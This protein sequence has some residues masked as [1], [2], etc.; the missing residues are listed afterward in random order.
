MNTCVHGIT[1]ELHMHKLHAACNTVYTDSCNSFSYTEY[2]YNLCLLATC[3]CNLPD[4][5][6]TGN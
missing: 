2:Q 1:D 3:N 5:N 6:Y 4:Q